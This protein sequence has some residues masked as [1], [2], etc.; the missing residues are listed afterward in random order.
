MTTTLP[1]V[2]KIDDPR[3]IELIGNARKRLVFMTPGMSKEVAEAFSNK[4]VE[5][6]PQA[7]IVIIDADPEVCR[8]GYGVLEAITL[9]HKKAKEIGGMVSQQ[10]GIRIALLIADDTTTVYSPPPLLIEAG[11]TTPDQPNAIFLDFVPPKVAADVGAGEKGREEQKI[12]RTEVKASTIND[13]KNDLVSN[14]PQKFDVAQ[15]VR[16]FNSRIEFVDFS[17]EGHQLSR[18]KVSI[19]SDLM[20]LAKDEKTKRLLH[21]YFQLI[22]N[23]D[24]LLS[25]DKIA[26][27]KN[28]IVSKYLIV[29]PNYG[30]VIRRENKDDF[31]LA[32][33]TL[34]KYNQRFQKR[35]KKALQKGIDDNRQSLVKALCPS[36]IKNYP[37]RWTKY[38]GSKPSETA[39]TDMLNSELENLF[40][41]ADKIISNIEVKL[42]FKGVTYEM[43]ND[44]KFIELVQAKIPNIHDVHEEYD[45]ARESI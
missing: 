1:A 5:L 3:L 44:K 31:A 18:K 4:W 11:G 32:V 21:G 12:G 10:P 27:L 2:T 16:V 41:T 43:L 40:G 34:K 36:V 9:L 42:M 19:P 23:N 15:K 22:D 35:V 25:G 37:A 28:F 13:L 24:K 14:P 20:G 17:M 7:A 45:A 33:A 29:L 26:K 6:G 39:V 8:M 30:T 38:I